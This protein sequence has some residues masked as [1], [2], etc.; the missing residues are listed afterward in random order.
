MQLLAEST[1][2]SFD[3]FARIAQWTKRTLYMIAQSSEPALLGSLPYGAL[4]R[5]AIS[6]SRSKR[7]E[8]LE[9]VSQPDASEA[10]PSIMELNF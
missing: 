10:L 1:L 7:V 6:Q 9:V 3:P 2:E 5:W 8:A 4:S